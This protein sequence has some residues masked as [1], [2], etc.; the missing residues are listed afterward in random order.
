MPQPDLKISFAKGS[1]GQYGST[2]NVGKSYGK[3]IY[4]NVPSEDPWYNRLVQDA[5]SSEKFDWDI[6]QTYQVILPQKS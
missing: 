4:K 3:N 5:F 1:K 6:L 2:S